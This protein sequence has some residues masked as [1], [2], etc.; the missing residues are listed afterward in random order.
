[1]TML[2]NY[3]HIFNYSR[4]CMLTNNTDLF[5][6]D[7]ISY[8]M[9]LEIHNLSNNA[10]SSLPNAGNCIATLSNF[11]ILEI[12]WIYF[13]LF[14]VKFTLKPNI[15]RSLEIILNRFIIGLL[16]INNKRFSFIL[17]TLR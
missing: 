14:H 16:K 2:C 6:Y 9:R 7:V 1:M 5:R 15:S 17:E 11:Q 4:T 3:Y 12:Q 13:T 8:C 10:D